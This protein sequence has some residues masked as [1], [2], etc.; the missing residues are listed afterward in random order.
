[1][2]LRSGRR[3]GNDSVHIDFDDASTQW[4]KNKIYCGEGMFIYLY[5]LETK[6]KEIVV[7]IVNH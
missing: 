7:W 1:M 3:I 5:Y 6:I 2:I 4:L